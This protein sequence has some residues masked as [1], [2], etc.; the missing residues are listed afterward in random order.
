MSETSDEIEPSEGLSGVGYKV[1]ADSAEKTSDRRLESNN[2]Y[3]AINGAVAGLD[4]FLIKE[5]VAGLLVITCAFGVLACV[6][7]ALTLIYYRGLG[8][9]KF[10]LLGEF[11]RKHA[12]IGYSHE[13][14]LFSKNNLMGRMGLSLSAMEIAIALAA[15]IGHVAIYATFGLNPAEFHATGP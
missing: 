11:E 5:K 3:L 12:V 15:L 2:V 8:A 7:W 10:H 14:R 9:A 13:W 4:T 6:M 1:L